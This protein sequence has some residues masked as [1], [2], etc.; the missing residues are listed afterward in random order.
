MPTEICCT[1][2]V[3]G[4]CVH[5]AAPKSRFGKHIDCSLVVG[6]PD[7]RV[8]ATMCKIMVPYPKP[9]YNLTPPPSKP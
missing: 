7:P 6:H 8:Y 5:P 1:K 2:F 9:V 3:K 4:K